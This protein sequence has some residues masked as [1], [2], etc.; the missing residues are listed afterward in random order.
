M[1]VAEKL[2]MCVEKEYFSGAE[3]S[4]PGQRLTISIGVSHFP[5]DSND[6]YDLLNLAD[7]ALYEAKNQGRNTCVG[8]DPSLKPHQA[9]QLTP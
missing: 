7:T 3:N 8:W 2:R 5:I 4:Q 1:A 6:I 9:S